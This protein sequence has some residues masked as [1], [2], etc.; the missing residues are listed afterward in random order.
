M[1]GEATASNATTRGRRSGRPNRAIRALRPAVAT[2]AVGL[3][4]A[5]A[6]SGA[7]SATAQE[8]PRNPGGAAANLGRLTAH[9]P[10]TIRDAGEEWKAEAG[11]F[12]MTVT[13]G[14]T[15]Q[16]YSIDLRTPAREGTTYKEVGWEQSSLH[17]NRNA[18]KI[19]W[20]L[21]HS[22]PQVND[23]AE[24]AQKAGVKTLDDKAAAAGTQAAIW[25]FSDNVEARPADPGAGRLAAYLTRAA[26]SAPQPPASLA[27]DPPAVAGR[28]GER[29]GPVTVRTQADRVTVALAGDAPSGVKVVSKDGKPVTAAKGGDRL[30]FDIPA[31]AE[32]GTSALSVQADAPIPIGRALVSDTHSQTQILAGASTSTVTA[33]ATATW[34]GQKASGAVP[35]LS[36]K[37]NCAKGGVGITATN[38]G[39]APFTFEL[40]GASHTIAAGSSRTVTIPLQED[41]AYDLTVSGPGGLRKNFKGVLD[42]ETAGTVAIGTADAPANRPTPATGGNPAPLTADGAAGSS[43]DL[44]ATGASAATPMIGYLALGMVAIGACAVVL[45]RKKKP[46]ADAASDPAPDDE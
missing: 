38:A 20:I 39:D 30:Y 33:D 35:A 13:G 41:Q 31:D 43:E 25:R 17:G 21:E 23:L 44:A 7:G 2:L 6:V 10:V 8:Q 15:L 46:A 1:L 11:L 12:E 22:Y 34:A 18:G 16:S 32:G 37:K 5:G 42:C 29:V 26:R 28:A 27:L 24:L 3:L 40:L 9:G 19:R 36:A 4:V 14:G 45:L